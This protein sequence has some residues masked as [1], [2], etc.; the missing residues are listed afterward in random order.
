MNEEHD[1][2][3]GG[4]R[5][6]TDAMRRKRR[7]EKAQRGGDVTQR[8]TSYDNDAADVEEFMS[9]PSYDKEDSPQFDH[10]MSIHDN[11]STTIWSNIVICAVIV[12]GVVVVSALVKNSFG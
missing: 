9:F 11:E 5:C 12:V 1:A 8:M 7:E 10:K 4:R 3:G 6:G 2:K